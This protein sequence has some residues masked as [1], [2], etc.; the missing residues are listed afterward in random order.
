MLPYKFVGYTA[1]TDDGGEY[2]CSGV[3]DG[4]FG[5]PCPHCEVVFK[6]LPVDGNK[7]RLSM[8]D[9]ES[10]L[11]DLIDDCERFRL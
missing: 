7:I 1:V 2:K 3:C 9:S 6:E 4:H 10:D 8:L 11:Q 5:Y